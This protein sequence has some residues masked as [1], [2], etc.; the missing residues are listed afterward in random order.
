[1]WLTVLE[2]AGADSERLPQQSMQTPLPRLEEFLRK[3]L[4][5]CVSFGNP[6]LNRVFPYPFPFLLVL[7]ITLQLLSQRFDLTRKARFSQS[8]DLVSSYTLLLK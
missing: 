4:L 6:E 3:C 8:A 2:Q 1:M 7:F 5:T